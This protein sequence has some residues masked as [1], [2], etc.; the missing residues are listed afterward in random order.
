MSLDRIESVPAFRRSFQ[1]RTVIDLLRERALQQPNRTAYTFLTDGQTVESLTYSELEK[2]ARATAAQFQTTILK[3]QRA[4]LLYPPGLEYIVAFWA[5]I[6][7][8][9]IAIPAY[10]PRVNRGLSRLQAIAA[11]AEAVAVLTT[12]AILSRLDPIPPETK[13]LAALHW[14]VA[15]GEMDQ[16]AE[17]WSEPDIDADAVAFLQ[18]TSGSTATP[19][20]VMVTHANLLHNEEMIRRVFR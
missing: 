5:C 13:E 15:S 20:G 12:S 1:P 17:Q 10:P 3:G 2:R 16:L 18:Y 4:L 6:Y 11:D 19:K 9:V 7:A 8:G 14:I